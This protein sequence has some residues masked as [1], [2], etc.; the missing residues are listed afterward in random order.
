MVSDVVQQGGCV[1]TRRTCLYRDQTARGGIPDDVPA[2]A[3]FYELKSTWPD[4]SR[5]RLRALMSG[6]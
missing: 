1:R 5:K 6:K 3:E 2:F 4:A